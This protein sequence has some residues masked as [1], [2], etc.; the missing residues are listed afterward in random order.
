MFCMQTFQVCAATSKGKGPVE[1]VT[2]NTAE[3]GKSSEL[4]RVDRTERI[5]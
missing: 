3:M 2:C 5:I 4:S 1:S